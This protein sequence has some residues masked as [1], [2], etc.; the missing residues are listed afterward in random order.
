MPISLKLLKTSTFRLAA[1]YLV[2]FALSVGAILGYVYWNTVALLEQQTENTIH[3]EVQGFAEQYRLRGLNGILDTVRR[4]S[5]SEE[6]SVYLL[7]NPIGRRLAGNLAGLPTKVIG[8][9]PG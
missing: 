3:A 7:T 1:V 2:V 6:D 9:A 5:Q 8:E 4:R